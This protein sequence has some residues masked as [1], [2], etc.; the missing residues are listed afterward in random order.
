MIDMA[1]I[2]FADT[3]DVELDELLEKRTLAAIPFGGRYRLI[4]FVLSN[5]VNAG[6][7]NIGI[8]TRLNYQSL[9]HHVRSGAE[10]DL[11]RKRSGL[12]F[13]PPFSTEHLGA[14]YKNRL[15][16]LE[17]NV[18]FLRGLEEKY[19][20]MSGCSDVV[21]LD[22]KKALDYHIRTGARLTVLYAPE[23]INNQPGVRG[24]CLS[25]NDEGRITDFVVTTVNPKGRFI[26]M[27]MFIMERQ[28]LL[29]ILYEA[30]DT[31]KKSFRE[32]VVAPM[33][34]TDKV[35]GYPIH[36]KVLFLD[37]LPGYLMSNL[38]LLDRD[39]R[40]NLFQSDN[41]PVITSVKDSPPTRYGP[42]ASVKNS[43]IADG[44]IIDGTVENSVI[45]RGVKIGKG[46]RVRNCV[47]MQDSVVSDGVRLDYAVLDKEVLIEPD[48]ILAG[49]ITQ[50]FFCRRNTRI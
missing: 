36:E 26:S 46:A 28:D 3:Y 6:M 21:N 32:D 43:L 42:G 15:H 8:I 29:D 38:S 12:T 49:Y 39:I 23:P 34:S 5:A 19:V 2:V 48:R 16:S 11:D 9:M 22:L 20:I 35:M 30:I 50:P 27:N 4:D 7:K 47:I 37:N 18:S 44:T 40:E 17:A 31:G 41:G 14:V 1:G 33:L 45:F 25:V 10:W 13:L 24:T